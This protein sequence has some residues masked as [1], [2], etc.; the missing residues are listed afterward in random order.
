MQGKQPHVITSSAV[1]ASWSSDGVNNSRRGSYREESFTRPFSRGDTLSR[2]DSLSRGDTLSRGDSLSKGDI[3][4]RG[5]TLSRVE[6]LSRSESS[7]Y[8]R[9]DTFPG[10]VGSPSR[11]GS[12]IRVGD[13]M[14]ERPVSACYPERATSACS[15]E[16]PA[17]L[18]LST[19]S[20]IHDNSS[21]TRNPRPL[22]ENMFSNDHFLH[23][24]TH[25]SSE[26]VT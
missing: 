12:P 14:L 13:G 8:S 10:R 16:D 4:S 19:C 5:D 7:A 21:C 9:G 15:V 2:G 20:Y 3:L 18:L 17:A 23:P 25:T 11:V 26:V 6:S 24:L 22:S 1:K